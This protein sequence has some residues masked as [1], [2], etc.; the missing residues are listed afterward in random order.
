MN[1]DL[2]TNKY[3][4]ELTIVLYFERLVHVIIILF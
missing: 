2:S 4:E 1:N 3:V